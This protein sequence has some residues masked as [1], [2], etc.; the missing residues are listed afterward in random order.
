MKNRYRDNPKRRE[1]CL[2]KARELKQ[3]YP[4]KSHFYSLRRR[5][6]VSTIADYKYYG[7]KGI[8]CLITMEEIKQ[9]WI[10]EKAYLM[11]KPSIDR[12]DSNKDYIFNNCRFIELRVNVARIDR[13][14]RLRKVY[15]YDKNNNLIKIWYSVK[16]AVKVYGTSILKVLYKGRY[17][18][19]AKN[20]IWKRESD[21]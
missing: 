6:T 5:C 18:K 13:T 4:W 3:K 11:D 8:K 10:R 20:Y 14:N 12:K 21:V 2:K 1:Y 17:R 9:L 16:S 7:G 15:Q 19:T